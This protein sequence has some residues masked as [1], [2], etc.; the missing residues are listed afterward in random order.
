MNYPDN[1]VCYD[2]P[3]DESLGKLQKLRDFIGFRKWVV[4]Q[5]K[6]Y[7][8]EGLILLSTLTGVLLFDK[9]PKLCQRYIFDI[10]DYSY[11]NLCIFRAIERK[12]IDRSFFTAISSKGFEA[13][14]PDH[15]YVIAHNFNRNELVQDPKF[16]K[17]D[18]PLK[19]VWNGTVRFFDYQ[20]QYLDALKNDSR[21]EIIYH[22]SGIDLEK[23]KQYCKDNDIRN[24]LF[25]GAYDNKDKFKL[26]HDADILNNCYGGRVG[27]WLRYAISNRFYDGLIYRIPQ[28]V[29]TGVYKSDVVEKAGVGIAMDAGPDFADKLYNYYMSLETYEFE[30]S[31][32]KFLDEVIAED[33]LF[34]K[35]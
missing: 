33:D 30:Q 31:C 20:K 3:S 2:S 35:K 26:L 4:K 6:A 19:L 15:D 18:K 22:G 10:R 34:I 13:F 27:D 21:F 16:V 14:L 12:L 28:L 5:L 9:L 8:N 1:Y 25:T 29:E 23:Y 7:P 32:K 11:E 17:R 24:V